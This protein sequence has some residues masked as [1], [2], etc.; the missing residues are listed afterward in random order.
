M[1]FK[2]PKMWP[3]RKP[4]LSTEAKT[5]S[6]I[7]IGSLRWQMMLYGLQVLDDAEGEPFANHE[8]MRAHWKIDR[9]HMLRTVGPG[10]RPHAW[11]RFEHGM[12]EPLSEA[13]Q[14]LALLDLEAMSDGEAAAVEFADPRMYGASAEYGAEFSRLAEVRKR[15]LSREEFLAQAERFAACARFHEFRGRQD[16]ANLFEARS[17]NCRLA[18]EL[19][20][21]GQ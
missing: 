5:P 16:V 13:G 20:D 21:A 14:L 18:A 11:F 9:E 19:A 17:S 3:R 6:G 12:K 1:R 10:R 15:G 8:E 2:K 4:T 7:P